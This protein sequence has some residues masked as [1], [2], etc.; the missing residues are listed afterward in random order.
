MQKVSLIQDRHILLTPWE[1]YSFFLLR[2]LSNLNE[3]IQPFY[4]EQQLTSA[5]I[6][7]VTGNHNDSIM[8]SLFR[9]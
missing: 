8:F 5:D 2:C 4:N 7:K 6:S 9:K 3:N 1:A